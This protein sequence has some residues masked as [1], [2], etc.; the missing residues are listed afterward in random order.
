MNNNFPAPLN[1][2]NGDDDSNKI[3]AEATNLKFISISRLPYPG[4]IKIPEMRGCKIYM[5]KVF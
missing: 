2:F 1:A 4:T 5:F 3:T